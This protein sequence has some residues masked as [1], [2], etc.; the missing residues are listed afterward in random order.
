M[1]EIIEFVHSPSCVF[2][3]LKTVEPAL[4]GPQALATIE[5]A[6]KH[7]AYIAGGFARQVLQF[8]D[9]RELRPGAC[10]GK[11]YGTLCQYLGSGDRIDTT[12][13]FWRAERG[14]IDLFFPS[15][16]ALIAFNIEISDSKLLSNVYC[17]STTHSATE[18]H[19][20]S[21]TRVQIVSHKPAPI[22]ELLNGFDIYNA[23]VAFNHE[24]TVIPPQWHALEAEKMVH[25]HSWEKFN[26]ILRINKY[27]RRHGMN[28]LSPKS[29]SEIALR[30]FEI[31]HQ[32]RTNPLKVYLTNAPDMLTSLK[33]LLPSIDSDGLA[34]LMTVYSNDEYGGPFAVLRK[35]GLQT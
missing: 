27:Y 23:M 24:E 32:I 31:V 8:G 29:S 34:L 7:G 28:K 26:I 19:C 1:T 15:R 6:F 17:A 21:T 30:A 4:F 22:D 33:R 9:S 35:R 2:E 25:V 12:R 11:A 5:L 3:Y 18:L 14:D 16:T 10:P 20:D 13:R